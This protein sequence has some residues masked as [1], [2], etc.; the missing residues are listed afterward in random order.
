MYG[1]T[2]V[3]PAQKDHDLE[4]QGTGYAL[5][6]RF[7]PLLL[8]DRGTVYYFAHPPLLHFCVAG[9]F[10]YFDELE[11]LQVYDASSQ[12]AQ[13]ALAGR[14]F[15]LEK[16]P[17]A[18]RQVVGIKNGDYVLYRAGRGSSRASVTS[19][20][21]ARIYE[22]FFRTPHLLATRAPTIFLAALTVAGLG[23]WAGHLSG[24][25][26]LG[27][28]TGLVYAT[29]PEVFVRSS[30]GGYFGITNFLTLLLMAAIAHDARRELETGLE[31]GFRSASFFSAFLLAL[32]NHKLILFPLALVVWE[33]IRFEAAAHRLRAALFHPA[34]LGFCAGTALFWV[35]GFA[36]DVGVFWQDH[37]RNHLLD[38]VT[39]QNPLGYSGYPSVAGLWTEFWKHT[40]FL[41]LPLGGAS[42]VRLALSPSSSRGRAATD[43]PAWLI[44]V[45]FTAVA[46]SVVDWRMTKHL[47]PMLLPLFLAPVVWTAESDRVSR[48]R[49]WQ[50]FDFVCV[51]F[52][53]IV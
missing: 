50:F 13:A 45:V 7:E 10:L 30:Y 42:L 29:N 46:Y 53:G 44:W 36:I 8:T 4:I 31:R 22:N 23:I 12:R 11:K 27:L 18:G 28:L 25:S 16:T 15:V 51:E 34:L 33:M 35:Y 26:W 19:V 17:V 48:R 52:V 37:I 14:S 41:L 1:A 5:L 40:G 47:M 3:V 9:S 49:W 20:E 38:R 43:A 6:D 21:T 39:H 2:Q 32:A 24:Q